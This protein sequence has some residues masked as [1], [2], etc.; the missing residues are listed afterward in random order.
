MTT[1][2]WFS[3]VNLSL[4]HARR[5][6]QT[7]LS[8]WKPILRHFKQVLQKKWTQIK[9]KHCMANHRGIKLRKAKGQY[10]GNRTANVR[11]QPYLQIFTH[12]FALSGSSWL[13]SQHP[14]TLLG[15]W[16]ISTWPSIMALSA[17]QGINI[18]KTVPASLFIRDI[19]HGKSWKIK[20]F[21]KLVGRIAKSSSID[22]NFMQSFCSLRRHFTWGNLIVCCL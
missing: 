7:L 16:F 12:N 5:M 18:L 14:F 19:T 13:L 1:G 20:I 22:Q 10:T 4:K 8:N 21:P 6:F 17:R 15:L 2:L 3:V 9:H 11:H